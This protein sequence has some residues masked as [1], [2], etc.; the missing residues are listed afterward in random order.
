MEAK[1]VL[2]L[3]S[4]SSHVAECP[5]GSLYPY[6]LIYCCALLLLCMEGKYCVDIFLALWPCS[7]PG[8]GS[9]DIVNEF[10]NATRG[11]YNPL[12]CSGPGGQECD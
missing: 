7:R 9:A 2:T 6:Y 8:K 3:L 11:A 12:P 5:H 10:M 1:S 4:P